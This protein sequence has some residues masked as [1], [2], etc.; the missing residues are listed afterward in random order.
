MAFSVQL[1]IRW[2]I[3]THTYTQAYVLTHVSILNNNAIVKGNCQTISP[4]QKQK[5]NK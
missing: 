5:Y 4:K 2:H 3:F 1:D